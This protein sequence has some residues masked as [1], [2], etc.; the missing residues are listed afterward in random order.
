MEPAFLFRLLSLIF[1]LPGNLRTAAIFLRFCAP[2]SCIWTPTVKSLFVWAQALPPLF[3]IVWSRQSKPWT[4][5]STMEK[6]TAFWS[7][8]SFA[9]WDL[10]PF[11]ILSMFRMTMKKLWNFP[12]ITGSTRA[13][14]RRLSAFSWKIPGRCLPLLSW[15]SGSTSLREAATALSRSSA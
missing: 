8:N 12:K 5:Q 7:M 14:Y 2:W 9:W 10:C 1:K 11:R 15:Q 13:I 4:S 3:P 6:M